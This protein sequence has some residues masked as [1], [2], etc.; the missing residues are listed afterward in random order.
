MGNIAILGG[1]FNP[2]HNGHLQMA[3]YVYKTGMYDEILFMPTNIPPHKTLENLP[4]AH[5]RLKMCELAIDGIKEFK[6]SDYELNRDGLTYTFDTMTNLKKDDPDNK[7]S[8]IIG[9]DSL[10]QITKWYRYKELL[11]ICPL[12]VI[13]R[14]GYSTSQVKQQIQDLTVQFGANINYIEMPESP[15]SSTMIRNR[16][17]MGQDISE[18]VP[19]KVDQY[20]RAHKLYLG[21]SDTLIEKIETYLKENISQKRF[22]HTLAVKDTALELA[23]IYNCNPVKAV[24]AGYLHDCAKN[25]SPKEKI[26]L[27]NKYRVSVTAVELN[28]PELLH[29]KVGA[30]IAKKEFRIED[31]DI[32]NAICYHTTGR[33][34][35][36]L[37]EKIIFIAD[38]IEPN[39]NR[40][41]DLDKIRA[42][43]R[44]SLN[45]ALIMILKNTL[46]YLNTTNAKID[47]MT[48][49]TY[50]YYIN[51]K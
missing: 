41:K 17:Q 23:N 3:Q 37:L 12:V 40:A 2:I 16:I 31:E 43:A 8:L 27:C 47:P 1:T 46:E 51:L 11:K 6:T 38:Y 15:I 28:N 7:Y 34:E 44:T 9:F 29:A 22:I 32:I 25:I 30:L 21:V 18:Y 4:E 13:N 39:R 33:P 49:K 42:L 36:S 50:D 14:P 45:D 20:I 5:H 35:M 24:L 19:E 48:Q 10:M 26:R